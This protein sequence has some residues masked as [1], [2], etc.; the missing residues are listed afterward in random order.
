MASPCDNRLTVNIKNLPIVTDINKGDFIIV[1]TSEGTN[2]LD[3]RNL[4]ITLDNTTFSPTFLNYSTQIN[5][6]CASL[7]T[8]S[9]VF[10]AAIDTNFDLLSTSIDTNFNLLSTSIDTLSALIESDSTFATI[11][12]N[13]IT[14][15][16]LKS[17]NVSQDCTIVPSTG[18]IIVNFINNFTD[19]YYCVST[20]GYYNRQ[21]VNLAVIEATTNSL[22]LLPILTSGRVTPF[23][24]G[25][26]N[27]TTI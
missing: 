23:D 19:S 17:N 5:T 20:G 10:S 21:P 3:F 24:R 12:S 15:E 9:S 25:W 7:A 8:T 22:T 27:I 26:I 11:S 16:V 13:G 1:E 4:L 14:I 18:A 2:I 6:L